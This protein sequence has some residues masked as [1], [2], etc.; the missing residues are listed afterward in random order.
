MSEQV[1]PLSEA[2][3]SELVL[4]FVASKQGE[5]VVD[6]LDSGSIGSVET[7]DGDVIAQAAQ[8]VPRD[9]D[10]K[11]QHRRDNAVAIAALHNAFPRL[12]ATIR[13][14]RER[15]AKLAED[16]GDLKWSQYKRGNGTERA[17][18]YTEGE[19]DAL[20]EIAARIRS[21]A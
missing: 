16:A 4:V 20:H 14:E 7:P 6:A 18:P 13:A 17:N 12:M 21:G 3:L 8:M 11:Q 9:Q 10:M 1:K 5:W 15:A 2:E 19:S